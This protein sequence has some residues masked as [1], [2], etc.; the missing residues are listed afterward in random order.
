[1]LILLAGLPGTG[2]TTFAKKLAESRGAALISSDSIRSDLHLRGKYDEASKQ[3]VFDEMLRRTYSKLSGRRDV[4]VDSTFRREQLRHQFFEL[5]EGQ[6]IVTR[7][8]LLDADPAEVARRMQKARSSSEANLA[9]YQQMLNDFDLLREGHL[10][11]R[12]DRLTLERMV[13]AANAY[14]RI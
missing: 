9:V 3:E 13:Q 12:S 14:L 4:I 6:R 10:Q 2:K 8:L 5:A 7:I 1:M 11:L